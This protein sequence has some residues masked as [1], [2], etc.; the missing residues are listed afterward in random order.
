MKRPPRKLQ[1]RLFGKKNFLWSLVQGTSV[2]LAVT[3]VFLGGLYFGNKNE[4]ESR[5]LAF[6]TLVIANVMLIL[7]NLSWSR[8]TTDTIKNNNKAL[9]LVIFGSLLSLVL[10]LLVPFLREL[11]HF[12]PIKVED[13]FL[14]VIIGFLSVFWIKFFQLTKR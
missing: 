3:I 5:T 12:A 2:F 4:M 11:F 14:I 6:A 7:V 10:V 9:W 8:K 1:D 13:F